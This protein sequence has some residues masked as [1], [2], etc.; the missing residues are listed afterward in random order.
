MKKYVGIV[1]I[2]IMTSGCVFGVD[3][4]APVLISRG[5]KV[6]T[7]KISSGVKLVNEGKISEA[8]DSFNA[9]FNIMNSVS[10]LGNQ[11][12]QVMGPPNI[13]PGEFTI[14]KANAVVMDSKL[15]HEVVTVIK[16]KGISILEASISGGGILG[17]LGG[18]AIG[19][20]R[21]KKKVEQ[22]VDTAYSAFDATL[23]LIPQDLKDKVKIAIEDK[24]GY[25]D[26]SNFEVHKAEWDK[27]PFVK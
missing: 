3:K 5:A 23:S 21:A 12:T 9:A 10:M 19:I 27:I 13:D 4:K 25:K 14:D 16:E 2:L 20:L 24:L 7:E 1:F 6:A 11:L 18:L 22:K 15:Q 8:N 26:A 17:V